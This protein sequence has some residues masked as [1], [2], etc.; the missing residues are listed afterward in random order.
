M[1]N[2]LSKRQRSVMFTSFAGILLFAVLAI[3]FWPSRSTE[4]Y[5][6]GEDIEGLTSELERSVPEGYP[7]VQFIDVAELAGIDFNHFHGE[8]WQGSVH[9]QKQ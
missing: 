9:R 8:R 5:V 4:K 2:K 6:P 3:I 1:F 7:K